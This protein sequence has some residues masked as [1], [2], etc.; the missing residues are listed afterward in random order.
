MKALRNHEWRGKL[1]LEGPGTMNSPKPKGFRSPLSC[2]QAPCPSW[3]LK[4][5]LFQREDFPRGDIKHLEGFL[6]GVAI[7]T[8]ITR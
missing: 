3:H 6:M 4:V 1:R 8:S 5:P 7:V 2:V